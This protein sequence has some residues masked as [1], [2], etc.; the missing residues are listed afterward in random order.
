MCKRLSQ[1]TKWSSFTRVMQNY[2]NILPCHLHKSHR[3]YTVQNKSTLIQNNKHNKTCHSCCHFS[4]SYPAIIV[5]AFT[6]VSL[7][8]S[9]FNRSRK[10]G[11]LLLRSGP[12]LSPRLQMIC[13]LEDSEESTWSPLYIQKE[14]IHHN[15]SA[16]IALRD[17]NARPIQ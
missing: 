1:R 9:F 6:V 16:N 2:F 14:C 5:R 15:G 10:I 11:R 17:Q 12:R 4:F 3:K 8:I 13:P 7:V